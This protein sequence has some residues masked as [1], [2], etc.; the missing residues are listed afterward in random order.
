MIG[1][2][3]LPTRASGHNRVTLQGLGRSPSPKNH[4]RASKTFYIVN[5]SPLASEG[6]STTK[7]KLK[8]MSDS[9]IREKVTII[10]YIWGCKMKGARTV[11]KPRLL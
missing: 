11:H 9:V 8:D 10:I 6:V 5:Q 2:K 1:I 3:S 4:P 7:D